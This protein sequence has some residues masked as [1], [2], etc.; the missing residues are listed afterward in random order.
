M[1]LEE[2]IIRLT[3]SKPNPGKDKEVKK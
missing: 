2:L 1:T 3:D